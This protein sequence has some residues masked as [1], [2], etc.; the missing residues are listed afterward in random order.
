MNR[1]I[2][3]IICFVLALGLGLGLLWPKYQALKKLEVNI[4]QKETELQ[5]RADYFSLIKDTSEELEKYQEPLSKISVA[6]PLYTHLSLPPLF[7]FLNKAA[8]QTGLVLEDMS[9]V[10]ISQPKTEEKTAK[11]GGESIKTKEIQVNLLLNGSY[12][13]VRDFLQ[14][15]E[16]SARMIEVRNISF[17]TP[18]EPGE[19]FSFKLEIIAHS[20]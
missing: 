6:L 1:F 8:A 14:A 4:E 10:G 20:Y 16:K 18:E 12:P 5:T 11:K 9:L 13:A 19:P 15:L 7:D 2:I 3:T 17:L